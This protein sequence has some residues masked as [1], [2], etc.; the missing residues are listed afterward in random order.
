MQSSFFYPIDNNIIILAT[1]NTDAI[2]KRCEEVFK[3]THG[4]LRCIV[5]V[6]AIQLPPDA[7]QAAVN[8]ASKYTSEVYVISPLMALLMYA[9]SKAN[10]RLTQPG[11]RALIAAYLNEFCELYEI[12]AVNQNYYELINVQK[13]SRDTGTRMMQNIIYESRP[14]AVVILGTT[15]VSG[16]KAR[17]Q[18]FYDGIINVIV[19]E[20]PDFMLLAGG[21]AKAKSLCTGKFQP[22]M[23]IR[24]F[25][26]GFKI[27]YVDDQGEKKCMDLISFGAGLPAKSNIKLT[28]I[29]SFSVSILYNIILD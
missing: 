11:Q 19:D 14:H 21:I 22:P 28:N 27:D 2:I 13:C 8:I 4:R 29:R 16:I 18:E 9:V 20:R 3:M 25:A 15:G 1:W 26:N 7:I 23:N 5:L 10:I 12:E 17:V 24:D 6:N